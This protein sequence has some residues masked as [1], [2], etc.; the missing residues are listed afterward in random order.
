MSFIGVDIRA[1]GL[2]V[3]PIIALMGED[4]RFRKG[5]DDGPALD[6]ELEP[7][8]L[9]SLFNILNAMYKSMHM[10]LKCLGEL[11]TCRAD[12]PLL[13]SLLVA[14]PLTTT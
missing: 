12:D 8:D 4:V 13:R 10:I 3:R 1:L 5:V 6:S 9:Q 11:P 2:A 14:A 7:S